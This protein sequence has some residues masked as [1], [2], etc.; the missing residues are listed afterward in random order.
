MAFDYSQ[1]KWSDLLAK[2]QEDYNLQRNGG[3]FDSNG[4]YRNYGKGDTF[5]YATSGRTTVGGL[6]AQIS[7]GAGTDPNSLNWDNATFN[8]KDPDGRKGYLQSLYR[9]QDGSVGMREYQD[10]GDM[11]FLTDMAKFIAVAATMGTAVTALGGASAAGGTAAGSAGGWTSGFDLAGGA[12]LP[13]GASGGLFGGGGIYGTGMSTGNPFGDWLAKKGI[14]QAGK[15]V[16]SSLVGGGQSTGSTGGSNMS[17]NFW[18]DLL[19]TGATAGVLNNSGQRVADAYNTSADNVMK[20]ANQIKDQGKFTPYNI[21]TGVGGSVDVGN[22][23]QH[24][25]LSPKWQEFQDQTMAQIPGLLNPYTNQNVSDI[26]GQAYGLSKEWLNKRANPLYAANEQKGLFGAGSLLDKAAGFDPEAAAKSEYD[27]MQKIYAP[28]RESDNLDMENRLLQQGRLGLNY[29]SYGSAPELMALKQAQ[30]MQDL[31]ATKD[32]RQL[33]FDRQNNMISQAGALNNI[34]IQSGAAGTAQQK[35]YYDM[36]NGLFGMGMSGDKFIEDMTNSRTARAGA[37]QNMAMKPE[38]FVSRTTDQALS[39]GNSRAN[40]DMNSAR[41]FGNMALDAEKLRATGAFRDASF[42]NARNATLLDRITGK[43]GAGGLL[44]GASGG[45]GQIADMAKKLLGMGIPE[46]SLS[47]VMSEL[48]VNMDQFTDSWD[49]D[50]SN[51]DM[52]ESWD[53]F[54]DLFD[55]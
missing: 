20:I 19:S 26:S 29:G 34:G 23:E 30:R 11:G 41:L 33:A 12:S 36:A 10:T 43:D 31:N 3:G 14:S 53:D 50:L 55:F 9:N 52:S 48:G 4:V 38:E 49:F 5:D 39:A 22:G 1:L 45:M 28:T 40:A 13:T 51:L 46:E 21:R 54:G 37:L 7:F 47:Q 16:V 35:S 17:D 42:A 24:T 32:S 27:L 25:Y 6:P 15:G 44:S 18:L 8:Y 2:A